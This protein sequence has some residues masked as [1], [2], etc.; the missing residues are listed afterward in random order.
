MIF[1][2]ARRF[3][4]MNLY[5][6]RRDER[7]DRRSRA[8]TALQRSST[9]PRWRS[10][11]GNKATP[12]K[13]ALLDQRVVAGLGNI[14]VSRGAAPGPHPPDG[15]G[16][17]AGA[18]VGGAEPAPRGPG[19]GDPDRPDRGDRGRR[20]DPAGF[21]LWRWRLEAISSTALRSMTGRESP[22]RRRA[23]PGRSS[24]S[25]SRGGRRIIVR[26]ARRPEARYCE[27][28]PPAQPARAAVNLS[29]KGEVKRS[30]RFQ[31]TS[32]LGGEVG[33]NA[34]KTQAGRV[35][36]PSASLAADPNPP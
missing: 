1:A 28:P 33:Q 9:P 27:G 15:S 21:P 11:S 10:A 4:T 17:E 5:R 36:G 20:L 32:P 31:I 30:P 6:R 13:A 3:G 34:S 25:S 23:A 8:G 22:V 24:G 19:G 14:Y 12:M 7:R 2:D 26:S 35:R 16:E 18:E 29:P